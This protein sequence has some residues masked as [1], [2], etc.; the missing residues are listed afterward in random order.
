MVG[1]EVST[2][3]SNKAGQACK[4]NAG[5]FVLW[6]CQILDLVIIEHMEFALTFRC[7]YI[8]AACQIRCF[9]PKFASQGVVHFDLHSVLLTLRPVILSVL[10]FF[11]FLFFFFFNP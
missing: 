5:I 7:L 4:K 10:S 2:T 9:K 6:S 8:S 11:F 3:W 1:G